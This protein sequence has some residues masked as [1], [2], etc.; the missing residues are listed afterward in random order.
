VGSDT[1]KK[2]AREEEVESGI[3]ILR[4]GTDHY[5]PNVKNL[6]DIVRLVTVPVQQVT[7]TRLDKANRPNLEDAPVGEFETTSGCKIYYGGVLFRGTKDKPDSPTPFGPLSL[8]LH[9]FGDCKHPG[10][11]AM[12]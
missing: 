2:K 5:A 1:S 3:P 8:S 7:M 11:T 4:A 9:D 12:K 6:R 10:L